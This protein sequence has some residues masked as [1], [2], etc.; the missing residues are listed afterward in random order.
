VV[1]FGTEIIM[2]FY[3][4]VQMLMHMHTNTLDHWVA[5]EYWSSEL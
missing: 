3:Q 2:Q 5:I 4:S 1:W